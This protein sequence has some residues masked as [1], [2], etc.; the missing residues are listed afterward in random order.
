[1]K[2]NRFSSSV[3]PSPSTTTFNH[4]SLPT[5]STS[6]SAEHP[7]PPVP[8]LPFHHQQQNHHRTTLS[9]PVSASVI[10][11]VTGFPQR[12]SDEQV[13]VVGSSLQSSTLQCPLPSPPSRQS[14]PKVQQETEFSSPV[15]SGYNTPLKEIREFGGSEEDL[16]NVEGSSSIR[17][18]EED[19][20]MGEFL[21]ISLLKVVFL[22]T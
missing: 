17:D 5:P 19:H 21:L 22:K 11:S 8:P 2:T 9:R 6:V 1:L 12:T 7:L 14:S 10:P 15:N 13:A 20:A 3:T 16:K 18:N 4:S